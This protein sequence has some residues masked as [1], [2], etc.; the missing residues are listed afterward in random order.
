MML[1]LPEEPKNIK[2]FIKT[3]RKRLG[4]GSPNINYDSFSV[5]SLNKL[6]EYL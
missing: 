5:W 4:G 6:S 3:V 1:F 2:G